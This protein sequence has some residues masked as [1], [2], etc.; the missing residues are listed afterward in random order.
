MARKVLSGKL[1]LPMI[2]QMETYCEWAN[3]QEC[4]YGYKKHFYERHEKILLWL[5]KRREELLEKK[6]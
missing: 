1:T 4:Y 3:R 6:S 5:G 2:E